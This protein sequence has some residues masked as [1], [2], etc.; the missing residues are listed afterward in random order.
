[1][2]CN[3]TTFHTNKLEKSPNDFVD[4][5]TFDPACEDMKY[6]KFK[7]ISCLRINKLNH[8]TKIYYWSLDS[9]IY[10]VLDH[11]KKMDPETK[12][13]LPSNFGERVKLQQELRTYFPETYNPSID[14]LSILF[15]QYII[16][17]SI[18]IP[19]QLCELKVFLHMD[20]SGFLTEW[21]D[22]T[23]IDIRTKAIEKINTSENGSWLLRKSS[24]IDSD[25]IKARVVTIKNNTG[26]IN[27]IPI[28]HV[29]SFGYIELIVSRE[30]KMPNEGS[31]N[32]FPKYYDPIYTSYVDIMYGLSKKYNF[33]LS[34]IIT[35]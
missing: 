16:E 9:A 13:L 4:L 33:I 3:Y 1:M 23:G 22:T 30:D 27:H 8:P 2:T 15:N 12:L 14:Y 34:K 20:S 35:N 24:I 25:I 32:I 6:N 19:S 17:P 7:S 31:N 11:N 5:I 21:V 29:Y 26:D 10:Y 18:L 28:A